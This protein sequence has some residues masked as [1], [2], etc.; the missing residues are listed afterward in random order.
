[1]TNYS[2]DQFYNEPDYQQNHQL[3]SSI[4]SLDHSIRAIVQTRLEN[5]EQRTQQIIKFINESSASSS[6]HNDKGLF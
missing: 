3:F 2:I 6:P 5:I 1:M 4:E